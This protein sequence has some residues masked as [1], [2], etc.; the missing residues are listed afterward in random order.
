M[1]ELRIRSEAAAEMPWP[2]PFLPPAAQGTASMADTAPLVLAVGVAIERLLRRP[3]QVLPANCEET[4]AAE[5]GGGQRLSE[6]WLSLRL[7]GSADAAQ[8]RGGMAG[9]TWSRFRDQL[10]AAAAA[11]VPDWPDD[12]DQL[13]VLVT[14]GSGSGAVEDVILLQAP[15]RA[16]LLPQ[17]ASP[18]LAAQLAA[19]PMRITVEL[20]SARMS[21]DALLPLHKGQVLAIQPVREMQLRLGDHGIGAATLEPLPDGRQAATLLRIDIERMG[22]RT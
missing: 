6:H 20:A 17:P 10:L 14:L 21:L 12:L 4:E 11:A 3:V 16:A 7:G 15:P 5:V 22:D 9:A 8:V 2:E 19:M 1:S 18:A 13:A